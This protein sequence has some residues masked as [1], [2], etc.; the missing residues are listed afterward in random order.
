M[1][2]I[3]GVLSPE[4]VSTDLVCKMRDRL[5]HRGPD[6]AGLGRLCTAAFRLG[7]GA[8]PS[9]TSPRKPT[10]RFSPTTAVS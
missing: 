9:S 4:P 3:V 7:T 8:S 2:G 6:H 5:Q 10:S 1:C